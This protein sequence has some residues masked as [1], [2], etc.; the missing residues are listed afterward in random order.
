[1][2][3]SDDPGATDLAAD[4]ALRLGTLTTLLRRS[5]QLG[6]SPTIATVLAT[7]ERDGAKRV[8]ELAE[9]AGVAQPTMTSLLRKLSEDGCVRRGTEAQDQRV[10]TIAV[11]D[12]GR[13][14]LARVRA[15]RR[16]ALSARLARL[17]TAQRAALATAIPALDTLIDTW[18]VAGSA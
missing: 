4:L 9:L 10:V 1:M 12:E 2:N 8:S 3:S 13:D 11:T 6:V 16:Q 5:A 7:L 15:A 14:L 18:R 17:D